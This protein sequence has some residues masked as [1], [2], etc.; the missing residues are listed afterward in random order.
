[1]W[2][3]VRQAEPI[4][5]KVT[6]ANPRSDSKLQARVSQPWTNKPSERV[7]VH[8]EVSEVYMPPTMVKPGFH[9]SFDTSATINPRHYC[10]LPATK[11]RLAT[12]VRQV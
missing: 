11:S 5:K 10:P 7:E 9:M 1:M 12:L 3:A 6:S 8:D 4:A 2:L